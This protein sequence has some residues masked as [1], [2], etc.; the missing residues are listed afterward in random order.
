MIE[1]KDHGIGID[2]K[3]ASDPA[4]QPLIALAGDE[5]ALSSR[6]VLGGS[7]ERNLIALINTRP[8]ER[9]LYDRLKDEK[10][11]LMR[12]RLESRRPSYCYSWHGKLAGRKDLPNIDYA[13]FEHRTGTLL[14]VELK[15]FVAPDETR[16]MADRSEEIEKG[17]KQC[18]RLMSAVAEDKSLLKHFADVKDVLCLVVSAN[19]I[20]MSYVQNDDVPVINE[21]HFLE[22]LANASDLNEVAA[23]LRKREYLPRRGHDYQSATPLVRFFSWELEWYGF[24]PLTEEPFLPLSRRGPTLV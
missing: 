9:A 11:S 4:L 18:R 2:A 13:L 3:D 8:A 16:E 14:L 21:D 5:L 23:W 24:A 17:V 22:E 7:P 12:A 20:G 6:L 10:E 19:S 1:V 15:W